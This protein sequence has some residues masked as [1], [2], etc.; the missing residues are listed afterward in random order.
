[1]FPFATGSFRHIRTTRA[2]PYEP[3]ARRPLGDVGGALGSVE[4]SGQLDGGKGGRTT[5]IS[6]IRIDGCPDHPIEQNDI[7]VDHDGIEWTVDAATTRTVFGITSTL[8]NVS[9][10]ISKAAA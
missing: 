1:M 6:T 8:C 9:R 7:L 3:A 4:R 5:L 10:T 2:E